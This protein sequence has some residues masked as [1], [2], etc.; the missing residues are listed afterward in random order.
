MQ[1]TSTAW[2]LAQAQTLVPESFVE[3]TYTINDPEAQ[4]DATAADNGFG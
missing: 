2:K 4:V 3:I 1:N